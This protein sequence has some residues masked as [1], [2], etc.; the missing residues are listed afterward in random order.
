M[1]EESETFK[2]EVTARQWVVEHLSEDYYLKQPLNMQCVE[3]VAA[4]LAEKHGMEI[5]VV[6]AEFKAKAAVKKAKYEKEA[7]RYRLSRED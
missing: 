5:E 7:E 6:L 4:S 2:T 3:E 1:L